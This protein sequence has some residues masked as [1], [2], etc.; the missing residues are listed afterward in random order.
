MF[1]V[2][3]KCPETSRA[4]PTGIEVE[5]DLY[6]LV[7]VAHQTQCPLCGNNHVWWI[8]DAWLADATRSKRRV[9]RI[10]RSKSTL[11]TSRA[12]WVARP[13]IR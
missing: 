6:S 12:A 3:I 4:I 7:N 1:A 5:C 11:T 2:M 9:R 10:S 13:V 8:R